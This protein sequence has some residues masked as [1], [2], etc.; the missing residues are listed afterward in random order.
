MDLDGKEKSRSN[1]LALIVF[2][3]LLAIVIGGGLWYDRQP[4]KK[5]PAKAEKLSIMLIV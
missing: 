1:G 4:A 3:V 2:G 5:P